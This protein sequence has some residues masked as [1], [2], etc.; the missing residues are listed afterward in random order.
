[1][2]NAEERMRVAS[3]ECLAAAHAEI[4][5]HLSTIN[6][7]K[8]YEGM[9]TNEWHQYKRA[10]NRAGVAALT[11]AHF[12]NIKTAIRDAADLA[13]N[14]ECQSYRLL[15]IAMQ[16]IEMENESSVGYTS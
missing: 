15:A 11:N 8:T 3:T 12:E 9:R 4:E 7:F 6:G 14:H 10:I 1:M 13:P 5:Q 2:K 16:L